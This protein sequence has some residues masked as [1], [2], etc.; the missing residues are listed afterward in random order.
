MATAL[1]TTVLPTRP[2]L[3]I[4]RCCF[5]LSSSRTVDEGPGSGS[6]SIRFERAR[7]HSLL[8][9]SSD[10]RFVTTARLQP[11][12]NN[13]VFRSGLQPRRDGFVQSDPLPRPVPNAAALVVPFRQ[14]RSSS[15]P[16]VSALLGSWCRSIGF[17]A[18]AASAG[19]PA[20]VLVRM[21][22]IK[23]RMMSA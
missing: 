19:R 16:G 21:N 15:S 13:P 6:V 22:S 12:H 11:G 2:A 14:S 5:K 20:L 17:L 23:S 7:L 10:G 18:F 9:N 8:Q 3:R 1:R 4:G